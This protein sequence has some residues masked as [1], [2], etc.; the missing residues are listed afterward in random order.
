MW[1]EDRD[2]G[3]PQAGLG[4]R[5]PGARC[6]LHRGG[7][8]LLAAPTRNTT[9][10]KGKPTP[11]KQ[12]LQGEAPRAT[13]VS[14]KTTGGKQ[15]GSGEEA[16]SVLQTRSSGCSLPQ[17]YPSLGGDRETPSKHKESLASRRDGSGP[18]SGVRQG[19]GWNLLP[20][21]GFGVAAG[22]GVTP[23]W[24][25][26]ACVPRPSGPAAPGVRAPVLH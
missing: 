22:A 17:G 24:K 7:A 10:S 3:R 9:L 2:E 19:P 15:Q 21:W 4:T 23:A 16:R 20:K 1:T 14:A 8:G 11:T 13:E 25:G 26:S 18:G 12:A 6:E 5:G